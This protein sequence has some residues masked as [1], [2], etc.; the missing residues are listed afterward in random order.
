LTHDDVD[1]DDDDDDAEVYVK[2]AR[3]S[4]WTSLTRRVSRA[5]NVRCL[6]RAVNRAAMRV[7]PRDP[8]AFLSLL[9]ASAGHVERL[10]DE[11]DHR[12]VCDRAVQ[13]DLTHV[14]AG[15][16]ARISQLQREMTDLQGQQKLTEM[17][18][19]VMAP[20]SAILT[21]LFAGKLWSAVHS[22]V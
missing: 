19:Y 20:V 22:V 12:D 21:L 18:T 6:L 10:D 9:S 16:A 17:V 11:A 14:D 1:E 13:T 5:R 15:S 7:N 8:D 2:E 4:E 3:L